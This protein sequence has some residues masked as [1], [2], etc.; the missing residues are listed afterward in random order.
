MNSYLIYRASLLPDAHRGHH[1][2][3]RRRRGEGIARLYPSP[4]RSRG[5]RPSSAW[6]VTRDGRCPVRSPMSWAS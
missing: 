4:W 2:L 6:I 1:G 5:S 3:E